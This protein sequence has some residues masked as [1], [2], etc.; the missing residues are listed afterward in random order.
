MVILGKKKDTQMTNII[1]N[2]KE[3][4]V[5]ELAEEKIVA[6]NLKSL[7]FKVDGY[8]PHIAGQHYDIR[9]VSSDLYTAERSYSVVSA[10]EEK[11]IIEFGVE[12]LEKGEVSP[13]L[14]SMSV[15][16]KIEI[17]GPIGG[18]F[19]LE[20]RNDGPLFLIAGGSGI[21]PFISMLRHSLIIKKQNGI[22][23]EIKLFVSSR[24]LDRLAYK[25]ELEK[26]QNEEKLLEMSV[27]LTDNIPS[28]WKGLEGR[29]K[30]S[31]FIDF[32][33]SAGEKDADVFIC[34]PTGFVES[35]SKIMLNIGY[36]AINIKTERFG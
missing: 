22:E 36:S 35:A 24:D 32:F 30:D 11:N 9:L 16:K 7:R 5:A 17:R 18:H 20:D 31:F 21:T 14:W 12:L 10:P 2:N 23:R 25:D 6:S 1:K 3:W 34:G 4:I 28:N 19:I 33:G 8:I 27:T 26:L 13:Y 29:I 15:G